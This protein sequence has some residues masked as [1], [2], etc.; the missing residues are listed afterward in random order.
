MLVSIERSAS[1]W[2]PYAAAEGRQPGIPPIWGW[3]RDIGLPQYTIQGKEPSGDPLPIEKTA[4]RSLVTVTISLD[5]VA[6]NDYL[7]YP[8]L[9]IIA[10]DADSA[11][12]CS[13]DWSQE[14]VSGQTGHMQSLGVFAQDILFSALDGD[15]SG[16]LYYRLG[17]ALYRHPAGAA[18]HSYNQGEVLVY[19]L[20]TNPDVDP[21]SDDLALD[22]GSGKIYLSHGKEIY[23]YT[24]G[25]QVERV[26]TSS[27]QIIRSLFFN[28]HT[29]TLFATEIAFDPV[30]EVAEIN[31]ASGERLRVQSAGSYDA[32]VDAQGVSYASLWWADWAGFGNRVGAYN[33]RSLSIR[34]PEAGAEEVIPGFGAAERLAI[35]QAGNIYVVNRSGWEDFAGSDVISILSGSPAYVT[36]FLHVP[37]PGNIVIAGSRMVIATQGGL[38]EYPLDARSAPPAGAQ[39]ITQGSLSGQMNAIH[40]SAGDPLPANNTLFQDGK[41][42]RYPLHLTEDRR[43]LYFMLPFDETSCTQEIRPYSDP[44]GPVNASY[45][46][47]IGAGVSLPVQIELPDFTFCN[48]RYDGGPRG[49]WGIANISEWPSHTACYTCT[50]MTVESEQ[51]LFPTWSSPFADGEESDRVHA[52]LIFHFPE[53][54]DYS[55]T[56]T[57]DNGAQQTW[58]A[59]VT[60]EGSV[61]YALETRQIDPTTGA[62]VRWVINPGAGIQ[63]YLGGGAMLEIPD[64]A[65]P[66]TT[67]YTVTYYSKSEVPAGPD[68][69]ESSSYRYTF[70]LNP[71]PSVLNKPLTLRIPYDPAGEPPAAAAFNANLT[72]LEPLPYTLSDGYVNITFPAGDYGST[73]AQAEARPPRPDAPGPRA[74]LNTIAA[75][76]WSATGLATLDVATAHFRVTYN[77]NDTTAAYAGVIS[78]TLEA[79]YT[80]FQGQ[81]YTMPVET[82]TVRVAP[83]IASSSRPGIQWSFLGDYYLFFNNQLPTDD[84]QDTAVHEFYHVL[85]NLSP[86]Y[87]YMPTWWKEGA[88]YWAQYEMFPAHTSYFNTWI[89]ASSAN[90]PNISLANWEGLQLEQMNATMALAAYLEQKKGA[91]SVRSVSDA[92]A[93]AADMQA[94]LETVTGPLGPFYQEFSRDYWLQKFAP[95]DTWDLTTAIAP[96]IVFQPRNTVLDTAAA[97]LSSGM[98]KV[99]YNGAPGAPPSF[100]GGLGS[101]ARMP[102]SCSSGYVEVYDAAKTELGSFDLEVPPDQNVYLP[103]KI[104]SYTF[105]SPAYFFYVNASATGN[106]CTLQTVWETPTLTGLSPASVN[107]NTPTVITISGGGFGPR[108]GTLLVGGVNYTPTSWSETSITFT[109]PAQTT[110]GTLTVYVFHASGARSNGLALTIN[111]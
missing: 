88:S 73:A 14:M 111:P 36:S 4:F 98:V 17:G 26:Y 40:L 29:G 37:N 64:G 27:A 57:F 24:P 72:I 60:P 76:I 25:G 99:Y 46:L 71:E 49:W 103:E 84:L 12:G 53:L 102:V 75:K 43:S 39:V 45:E 83:W 91:G 104:G 56:A 11:S 101:A 69:A 35:D 77:P 107:L 58:T 105:L 15:A 94:A 2:Y 31:P 63:Y 85:Q 8:N 23:R 52:D 74:A 108:T 106:D 20:P 47:R 44:P 34:G 87:A 16:N 81:G 32:V 30:G 1:N 65:L 86:G 95:V 80:H 70:S 79:A 19:P 92:L 50:L 68:G 51:G 66:G 6:W 82:V 110:P 89:G 18:P 13:V 97:G 10:Q 42:L 54:G 9:C 61:N 28:P 62:I 55:F 41:P 21:D 3:Y 67:P 7:V 90:F 33:S 5:D 96:V 48:P 22:P 78:D 59:H 109:L 100:T 93:T 38:K